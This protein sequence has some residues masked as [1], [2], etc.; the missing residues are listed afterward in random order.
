MVEQDMD[1]TAIDPS[2]AS[3]HFTTAKKIFSTIENAGLPEASY[4]G[5]HIKDV[6]EHIKNKTNFFLHCGRLLKPSGVCI[7]VFDEKNKALEL[8]QKY[9]GK[10]DYFAT[11]LK[12]VVR[13]AK[14]GEINF[15]IRGSVGWTP[16]ETEKD[17]YKETTQRFVVVG[18]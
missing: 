1:V 2:L 9:K 11:N 14:K 3:M 10:N 6:L 17:W 5:I 15:N 4:D 18:G 13:S 8:T 16:R 12:S 7:C